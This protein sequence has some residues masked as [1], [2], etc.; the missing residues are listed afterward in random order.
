MIYNDTRTN[1]RYFTTLQ[2]LS[3]PKDKYCTD[4]RNKQAITTWNVSVG[5]IVLIELTESSHS[6]QKQYRR[7]KNKPWYPFQC[8]YSPCQII[9]LFQEDDDSVGM[10][11]R[12][13]YKKRHE[14][15]LRQATEVGEKDIAW[16]VLSSDVEEI[17]ESD[18][19]DE[20]CPSMLLGRAHLVS[21]MSPNNITMGEDGVPVVSY[22][23]KT[24]LCGGKK[25]SSIF[26]ATGKCHKDEGTNEDMEKLVMEQSQRGHQLLEVRRIVRGLRCLE[27]DDESIM[28]LLQASFVR[29]NE[30]K[31]I[32][33]G[34]EE[35]ASSKDNDEELVDDGSDMSGDDNAK[36]E[37]DNRDTEMSD[38]KESDEESSR[39]SESDS[40]ESTGAKMWASDLP[41][42]VDV[43]AQKA[44]Y[45]SM[46]IKPPSEQYAVAHTMTGE[47]E[48]KV[49]VGDTV[50]IHVDVVSKRRKRGNLSN[51]I[52]N[53]PY[54]V[55]WWSADIVAIYRNLK[56]DEAK[57]LRQHVAEGLNPE[58]KQH[59]DRGRF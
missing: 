56:S 16:D 35:D 23:C 11:I 43:S 50:A 26:H 41:F 44:F 52:L 59:I 42:H 6:P 24:F 25:F 19:V 33:S 5:D 22:I 10:I 31:D 7:K 32:D 36:P 2:D 51:G 29:M 8:S 49:S 58:G 21:N 34:D 27:L 57:T 20:C 28:K 47:E 53:H 1:R 30:N 54:K 40:D 14:A 12:W 4:I 37:A 9:A 3:I 55:Q 39:N 46:K 18:G 38:A 13:F 15:N 45:M 48:W 17:V